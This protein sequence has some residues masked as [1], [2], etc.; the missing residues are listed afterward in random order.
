MQRMSRRKLEQWGRWLLMAAVVVLGAIYGRDGTPTN[1]AGRSA[2]PIPQSLKGAAR[3]ID[4]DS[5]FVG[6]Q[7]VRM[8]GID[9]PEGRQICQRDDRPWDCGN[10]AREELRR[11]IGK[12][13]VECRVSDRDKHERFLATCFAGGSNLN[14]AMVEAGMA[15]AYGGY[16]REEAAAKA[17][18]RGLWAS[19][20]QRPRDWRAERGI[21]Q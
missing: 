18:R 7:E 15:V 13:L 1:P 8:Q 19:E 16:R 20:F 17:A 3:A 6:R 11:L 5:L 4:G 10:A 2:G 9:A 21:G 14:A 12:N